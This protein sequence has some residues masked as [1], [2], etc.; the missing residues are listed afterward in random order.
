ML[1]SQLNTQ[2]V[3]TYDSIS[4]KGIADSNL[5][6]FG[7]SFIPTYN[8]DKADFIVGIGCDF[9]ANWLSPVEHA[10]QY[11]ETRKLNKDEKKMSRHVQIESLLTVTGSNADKRIAL[12]PSQLGLAVVNLYNKLTGSSLPSKSLDAKDAAIAELAKELNA[13]KGKA[14]V[15]CGSND[16]NIQQVVN[17]I[18]THLG[19]Y[20]STINK[21]VEDYTRQG[22]DAA[23]NALV[24]EMASGKV[25][26]ILINNVNPVYS[27][28]NGAAFKDALSKVSLSVSFADRVDETAAA[29]KIVA[30]DHHYLE[31]WTDA[32]PRKGHYALG[33]PTINPLFSTRQVLE[34]ILTW[35]GNTTN[36]HD[37]ISK[38]WETTVYPS[39]TGFLSFNDFWFRSLHDGVMASAAPAAVIAENPTPEAPVS[40]KI[41]PITIASPEPTTTVYGDVSNA[42]SAIVAKAGK[43]SGIELVVYQ[44]TGAGT[45]NQANNPWLQELPDPITKVT[46]DNYVLMNS[47]EMKEKG[48][49]KLMCKV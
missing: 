38:V 35:A 13:S 11:A 7:K 8:F 37:Y 45:G 4:Y 2:Q 16:A 24:A 20:G 43:A 42:A 25:G 14:L 17:A 9:L 23:V 36:A 10:R 30:P 22:N 33:Q 15:V 47:E 40:I 39:S 26:A 3:V 31:S 18:N 1:N 6:S 28:P 27:L 12:K 21:D 41:M 19:S 32:N 5:A 46:W 44:K 34:S 29:C 49:N 48:L